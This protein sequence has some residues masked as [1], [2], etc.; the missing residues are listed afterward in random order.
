MPYDCAH[1]F[2]AIDIGAF[3]PPQD[4][5]AAAGAFAQRVRSSRPAAGTDAVMMPG[6]PAARAAMR[7]RATCRVAA[8]TAAALSKLAERLEVGVPAALKS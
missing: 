2:L 5:A 7:N 1:F 6:D 8:V 3:R 4:F